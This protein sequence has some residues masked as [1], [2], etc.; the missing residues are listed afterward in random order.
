MAYNKLIV[1]SSL[2]SAV[3]ASNPMD[4]GAGVGLCGVLTLESGDGSG[5][6]D[7]DEPAVHGL[8]PEVNS[9]GDSECIA[10]KDSSSP[11][12]VYSCYEDPDSSDSSI[13]S[14]ETH[15]WTSH[16][17]CS[18]TASA[19]DFFTQIC[20]LASDPISIMTST[21]NSGGSLSDMAT[22]LTNAGYEIYSEDTSNSQVFLFLQ[23]ECE[24]VREKVIIYIEKKKKKI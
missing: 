7:H 12:I 1:L 10:P 14:F 5:N 18:G 16:G 3:L 17:V 19:D 11:T 4:C 8:W 24:R 9:Y 13:I 23:T 21:K 6:Y 15:E 20:D 2:S 22:A